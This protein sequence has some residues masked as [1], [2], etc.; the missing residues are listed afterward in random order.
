ML[1]QLRP[2]L[3][4]AIIAIF[5]TYCSVQY[6]TGD[7]GFFSQEDR[8]IELSQKEERLKALQAEREDLEARARFLRTDNLSRELL[9]E[10][11][12]VLLGL[13]APNEYVIRDQIDPAH[14]S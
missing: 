2:Y 6:L 3:P 8:Q 14:N 12:R 1:A 4:T 10:R 7:R 5:L 13:N 11:A 9:K